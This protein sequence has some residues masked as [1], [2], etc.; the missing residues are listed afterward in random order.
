M[1]EENNDGRKMCKRYENLHNFFSTFS[2]SLANVNKYESEIRFVHKSSA[3]PNP[4]PYC[5]CSLIIFFIV[6]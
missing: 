6:N 4:Q 3:T 2:G 5:K 1:N